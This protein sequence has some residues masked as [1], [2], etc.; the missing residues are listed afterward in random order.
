SGFT[1]L[2][3]PDCGHERLLAF[4]C[5]TRHFCP[6]CHQR[7]VRSTSEWIATAV[8]HEV[9]H[10]QFVFTIPK[11]L[12]DIFRKRRTLLAHLFHCAMETLIAAFRAQLQLPDGRI[13]AIAAVHT[14]GDYLIFH[15][16]LHVLVADGLFAPDGSFHYLPEGD[17]GPLTELFR[18]HFLA[19]LRAQKLISPRKLDELLGWKHS[20]FHVHDGRNDLVA[21]DDHAG[22]RRLAQ[23]LLRHPFSLQKITWNS[24]TKTV[25]YRSKR[26]HSTKRNF[27]IFK[28]PDFI[29]AALLH[30]PPKG[31]QTVRYYG[32]YSNKT[33]GQTS[34]IPDRIIRLPKP[35]PPTEKPPPAQILLIPAPPKQS[36]RDMRPLWRDLILQVWGGDPLQCPCCKGNMKPVRKVIRREE[37]QFFLRLHGLWEGIIHLPRP[38]P[39]PFDI[40]TMEPIEPPWQA[41]KE[42]IPDDEPDLDW[43]NR[44]RNPSN[45]PDPE[46]FDQ[47]PTWKAP[48]IQLDDGRILV[49][50]ST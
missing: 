30:L 23:Y 28:A 41:I 16:H 4:T 49:L 15:P 12:R 44:P 38:P 29:A 35:E 5:K 31:Q 43:F 3:C 13:G 46:G 45:N 27:E 40:E 22:R 10:R 7:R 26:H 9:P 48:E 2:E 39:P 20:G 37:I 8:C 34:L 17:I 50:E 14:F 24:A 36:A 1:R 32:T 11:V 18:H 19:L 42:W 47:S 33:R 21:A 6:A 25:I